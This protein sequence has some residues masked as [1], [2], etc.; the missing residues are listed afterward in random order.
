M[1]S[2]TLS[3]SLTFG[4]MGF[5]SVIIFT[6]ALIVSTVLAQSRPHVALADKNVLVLNAFESNVPV[7]EF[8][9]TLPGHGIVGGSLLSWEDMPGRA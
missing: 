4:F 8:L 9:D 3:G 5:V 1:T 2:K 6:S 7:F